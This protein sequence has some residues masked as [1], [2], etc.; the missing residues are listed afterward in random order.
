MIKK[1]FH[2][3]E[4][5]EPAVCTASVRACP[6]G[7]ASEHF[8]SKEKARAY[9]EESMNAE[10][11]KTVSRGGN[12]PEKNPFRIANFA[13]SKDN[14]HVS[15][16]DEEYAV[17]RERQTALLNYSVAR[18]QM[19]PDHLINERVLYVDE[20]INRALKN[21]ED[22]ES[23]HTFVNSN[24]DKEY[25]AER[26]KLHEEIIN[27]VLKD[28]ESVP[29]EGKVIFTG[30]VM[31]AGKT[32][33]LKSNTDTQNFV[34]SFNPDEI[35]QEMAKRGMIPSIPGLTPME[36][37]SLAHNE[38]SYLT[39]ELTNRLTSLK[40]NIVLDGTLR[41][42]SGVEK[43]INNMNDDGYETRDMS[44]IFIE[45]SAET[46]KTRAMNRY[47]SGLKK[48]IVNG[49]GFGGR[50]VSDSAIEGMYTESGVTENLGNA[51][52]FHKN[53][54]FGKSM[55]IQHD[56]KTAREMKI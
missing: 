28:A 23:L 16:T 55:F 45:V 53:N 14:A 52:K 47:K 39:R 9:F 19:I 37:Q 26:R 17:L 6:L 25:S 24:G 21:N 50:F 29:S 40:K 51:V 49:E 11:V 46:A 18:K 7:N 1:R 27:K 33:F 32:T 3:K 43:V 8:D 2:L 38:A 15:L 12:I 5:G 48:F 54:R 41:N 31:A 42:Y 30:G 4:N 10:T 22:T 13:V 35:K 20:S 44:L 36:S 56:G 34:S